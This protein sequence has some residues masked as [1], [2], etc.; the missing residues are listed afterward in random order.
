MTVYE[1]YNMHDT[2]VA[3]FV[4]RSYATDYRDAFV[5]GGKIKEVVR[6]DVDRTDS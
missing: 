4:M 6:A 2:F 3:L 1:V 5:P